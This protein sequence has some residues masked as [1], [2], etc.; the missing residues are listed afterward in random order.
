MRIEVTDQPGVKA[1]PYLKNLQQ[2]KGLVECLKWTSGRALPRNCEA[3]SSN[4]SK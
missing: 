2:K 4:P 1:K 3:L